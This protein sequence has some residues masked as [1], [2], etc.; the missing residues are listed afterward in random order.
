MGMRRK[1]I[2]R[3]PDPRE[4][5]SGSVW[6]LWE[7]PGGLGVGGPV[8]FLEDMAGCVRAWLG[9][10]GRRCMVR[11]RR[12]RGRVSFSVRVQLPGAL[13]SFGGWLEREKRRTLQPVRCFRRLVH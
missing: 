4:E 3:N 5:W 9:S 2:V 10:V 1:I 6:G 8:V 11:P 13:D 12:A 7:L